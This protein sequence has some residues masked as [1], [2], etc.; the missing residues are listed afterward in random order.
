M[1][2]SKE[3]KKLMPRKKQINPEGEK[4]LFAAALAPRRAGRNHWNVH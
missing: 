3:K 1:D 2:S 4:K